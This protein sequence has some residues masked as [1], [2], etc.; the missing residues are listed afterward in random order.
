MPVTLLRVEAPAG[1]YLTWADSDRVVPVRGRLIELPPSVTISQGL[2][3]KIARGIAT[4][5]PVE[6]SVV[7]S[8]YPQARTHRHQP[9][10]GRMK[11]AID[12]Q[13]P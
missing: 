11:H 4:S 9:H 1:P 5:G 13:L 6:S 8:S 3:G 2:P 10:P 12:A 7:P